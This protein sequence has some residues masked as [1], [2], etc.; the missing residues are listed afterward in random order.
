MIAKFCLFCT[1]DGGRRNEKGGERNSNVIWNCI[2][3]KNT[4]LVLFTGVSLGLEM[5]F[6]FSFRW[7]FV[8]G[9]Y[10]VKLNSLCLMYLLQ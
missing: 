5:L 9:V 7:G 10:I 6:F 4:V 8:F 2:C 3:V 1:G